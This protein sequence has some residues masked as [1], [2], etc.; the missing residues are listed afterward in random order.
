MHF[1]FSL[2]TLSPSLPRPKLPALPLAFMGHQ[3]TMTT[4]IVHLCQPFQMSL[5]PALPAVPVCCLP[6]LKS[7]GWRF[8]YLRWFEEELNLF[9]YILPI[10]VIACSASPSGLFACEPVPLYPA[11]CRYRLLC[12]SQCV[13]C[14]WT[15]SRISCCPRPPGPA[16]LPWC[17]APSAAQ[18]HREF[19][20]I[21]SPVVV[22]FS[23]SES[24]AP[25]V[26][27]NPTTFYHPSV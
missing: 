9:P 5:S 1:C 6:A 20:A 22:A 3:T 12:Q 8:T 4:S 27:V 24:L 14:L 25:P 17:G 15:C 2:Q 11:N 7:G 26:I 10:V 18:T 19:R 23:A 16:C 13:V 21:H